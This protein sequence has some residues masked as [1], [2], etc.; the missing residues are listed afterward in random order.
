MAEQ[1][2]KKRRRSEKQ[3]PRVSGERKENPDV[4]E[5]GTAAPAAETSPE[6]PAVAA[7][8]TGWEE[9]DQPQDV[10]QQAGRT[11]NAR[12]AP[13]LSRSCSPQA[14]MANMHAAAATASGSAWQQRGTEAPRN[15][16]AW[17]PVWHRRKSMKSTPAAKPCS[18]ACPSV[19]ARHPGPF[20]QSQRSRRS[21]RSS[22][23]MPRSVHGKSGSERSGMRSCG[24]SRWGGPRPL[25]THPPAVHSCTCRSKPQLR[26]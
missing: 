4:S 13:R 6:A 18:L 11:F 2:K 26:A 24:G 7:E 14:A 19:P 22:P 23:S 12:V 25:V 21:R 8:P 10:Q 17:R 20:F 16:A 9:L 15:H 5:K 3:Q 1:H